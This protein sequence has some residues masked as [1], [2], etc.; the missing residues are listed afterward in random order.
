[1]EL[2]KD[3]NLWP[4]SDKLETLE[5]KYG[6]SLHHMDLYGVPQPKKRRQNQNSTDMGD[7]VLEEGS[8][9]E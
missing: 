4:F 7:T 6:D 9:I 2:V 8:T 3:F 1:M 5:R